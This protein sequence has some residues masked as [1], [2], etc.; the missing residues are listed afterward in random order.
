[1]KILY[2]YPEHKGDFMFYWQ[3]IHFINELSSNGI[4]V[5]ILNPLEYDSLDH[6][7][8]DLLR[9]I[10]GERIDLFFMSSPM[11][12]SKDILA[13][14]R[15]EGIPSLCFRPDNLLIPY[16][17][18]EIASSFDLL[19]LT[20]KETE[21]LYKKWGARYFI[22]PYAANPISFRPVSSPL[23]R[24]VCFVGT[25]YGS[26][27]NMINSLINSNIQVDAFCKKIDGH[28]NEKFTIKYKEPVPSSFDVLMNDIRYYDG[29]KVIWANLL[30]R[31]KKHSL[32]DKSAYLQLL[33]KISFDEISNTYS[34]YALSLS[35][36]SAR[37]TDILSKPVNVINLRSFEI[38]MS[39]GLQ[40]CR[41][42]EE[43]SHYYEENKEILFY[44]DVDELKDK[45]KFYTEKASESTINMIKK[46]ARTRSENEHTWMHRF[47]LAFNLLGLKYK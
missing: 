3:R 44:S 35:S 27:S 8:N 22:A 15:K 9:R 14:I 1:M 18:K 41:Y 12:I 13:L 24:R 36:T 39:G 45:A 10:H 46:A 5:D 31:M 37:N 4:H 38:P 6:A 19:W 40:I 16:I 42:S 20:S 33:P 34:S 32:N 43:L 2:F 47:N 26:R 30:N 7:W 29:R 11:F 21:L 17:D 23:I 25:P 28:V